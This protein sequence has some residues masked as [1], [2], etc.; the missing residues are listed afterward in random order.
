[1][2]SGPTEEEGIAVAQDGRSLVTAVALQNTSLWVHDAQGERQISLEGNGADP[3]FTPDGKK[4]CYLIV[5]EAPSAFGFYRE[6]G[7][8]Q[9][10]D[11]ESGRS[12]PLVRGFQ[13]LDYDISAD[14]RGVVMWTTDAEGKNRLWLAPLDRSSPPRQIPDIEGGQPKFAPSGEILF[15]RRLDGMS[16]FVYRVIGW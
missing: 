14:G 4:L 13:V 7:E 10:A 9:V 8:L 2:T 11:V 1:M 16:T 3:K 6:P 12:E 15:R 5:R